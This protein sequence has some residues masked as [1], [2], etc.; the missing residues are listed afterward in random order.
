M[1]LTPDELEGLHRGALLHD[2][3]K[4]GIPVAVLDKPGKLTDEEYDIIKQHPRIG[5][6]IVEPIA[7]YAPVLPMVLQHHEHFNGRGYPDGVAGE[8]LSLGARILAVADVYDALISDRP[9]RKGMELEKTLSIIK[10]NSGT[11]FDP[12]AVEAFLKVVG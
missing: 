5:A 10:E 1:G 9:Y 11:Q 12:N 2:I 3:G 6:R 4:I 7:A 8:E